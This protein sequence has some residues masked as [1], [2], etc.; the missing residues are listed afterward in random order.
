MAAI[1]SQ[2]VR[3]GRP[4]FFGMFGRSPSIGHLTHLLGRQ[5]CQRHGCIDETH[6]ILEE[7]AYGGRYMPIFHT[8]VSS[9]VEYLEGYSAYAKE[10]IPLWE[11]LRQRITYKFDTSDITASGLA[12]ARQDVETR[13]PVV[14]DIY[15]KA[16]I[17]AQNPSAIISNDPVKRFMQAAHLLRQYSFTLLPQQAQALRTRIMADV[18]VTCQRFP[19]ASSHSFGVREMGDLVLHAPAVREDT[20]IRELR[21]KIRLSVATLSDSTL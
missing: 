7:A 8:A 12:Q 2:S 4:R 6:A 16:L 19:E 10:E 14:S 5:L 21:E 15:E 11:L 18:V 20:I 9:A 17:K 3:I 1:P 13:L